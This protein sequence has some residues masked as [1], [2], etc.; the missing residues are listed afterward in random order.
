MTTLL[1]RIGTRE[2]KVVV[3]G[4]GYVGLPLAVEVAKAR[5]KVTAYDKSVDKVQSIG[6]GVSY[7]NDV[8]SETL[9][10]LVE[11]GTPTPVSGKRTTLEYLSGFGAG[12][13]VRGRSGSRQR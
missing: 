10:P 6:R 5:F 11:A 4:A 8:S 3:V 2:A 9:A 13:H 7:V 12:S 1:E